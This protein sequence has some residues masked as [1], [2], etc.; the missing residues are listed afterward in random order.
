MTLKIEGITIPDSKLAREFTEL[1]R[2]TSGG[3]GAATGG[4][5]R[6]P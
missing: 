6:N 3:A 1:V 4:L 2:D 5:S